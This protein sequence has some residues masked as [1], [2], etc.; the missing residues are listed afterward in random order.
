MQAAREA[1]EAVQVDV[2][3]VEVAKATAEADFNNLAAACQETLE[4]SL[5]QA[6]AEVEAARTGRYDRERRRATC[7]TGGGDRAGGRRESD[8][9]AAELAPAE[10]STVEPGADAPPENDRSDVAPA[11]PG[12]A[13]TADQVIATLRDKIDRL[14]PVNMMAIDQFDELEQRFEFLTT[15]RQDLLDSIA[16]TGE[17]I[18][19]IDVTT[20]ERFREA[21]TVINEHLQRTFTT[22][23]GGGRAGLVLLDETDL[24]ESGIDIIAQPPGKRL[25]SIQLLSGGEKALTAM[26]LMFAIFKLQTQ[27]VLLARR[28]RCAARRCQHRPVRRDAPRDAGSDAVRAGYA[29]PEDHGDRRSAVW[30]HHGRARRVEADLCSAQLTCAIPPTPAG[31]PRSFR[32]EPRSMNEDKATR[33][34]RL[35]RRT[36]VLTVAVWVAIVSVILATGASRALADSAATVAGRLAEHEGL[37][38]SLTVVFYVLALTVGGVAVTLPLTWYR[39]FGLERRFGRLRRPAGSWLWSQVQTTAVHLVVAT[40]VVV[41]VYEALF[42]WPEWWWI[43]VGGAFGA[44]MLV[45]THLAPLITFPASVSRAPDRSSRVAGPFATVCPARGGP[46]GGDSRM[47]ARVGDAPPQCRARRGGLDAAGASH[48]LAAGRL[49]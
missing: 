36:G 17:A 16:S 49:Q 14:G 23:F 47:A 11:G 10:A 4:V 39:E 44:L 7:Q 8:T 21:F 29:Q 6:R 45:V 46:G 37:V 13:P 30:R 18:K 26:A 35:R 27:S 22:L 19:R 25:Q 41:A 38:R 28:N 3:Q 12:A 33:Y 20:R 9:D 15:Q 1:L 42:R 43:A 5:D 24:L 32:A 48:R 31:S 40:V 34:R 2:G